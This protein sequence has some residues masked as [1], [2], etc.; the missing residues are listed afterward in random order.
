MNYTIGK[1]TTPPEERELSE[2]TLAVAVSETEIQ[3]GEVI[4]ITEKETPGV[5]QNIS[6]LSTTTQTSEPEAPDFAGVQLRIR[7][8]GITT[9]DSFHKLKLLIIKV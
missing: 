3:F 4:E 5:L 8:T 1:K 6:M 7:R 2:K 9:C